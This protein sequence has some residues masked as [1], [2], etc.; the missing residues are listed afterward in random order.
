MIRLRRWRMLVVAGLSFG[1]LSAAQNA[2]SGQTKETAVRVALR[3]PLPMMKG[4][5]LKVTVLEVAYAPGAASS[6]HSHP[7]PVIGYV[8]SGAVRMQVKGE[9]EAVYKSGDTFFEAANGVRLISANASSTE[10]AKFVA[11]FLCDHETE[12]SVAPID[13]T[14]GSLRRIPTAL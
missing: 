2:P 1:L 5:R 8:V 9:P 12:L 7:C 3:R 14:G 13:R 4:D 11:Y 10:P 6:P